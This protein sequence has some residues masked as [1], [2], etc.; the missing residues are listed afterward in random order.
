MAISCA[1]I[2]DG[3]ATAAH[4]LSDGGLLLG[5]AEMAMASGIGADISAAPSNLR[6]CPLV[7]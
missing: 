3:S 1:L 2:L 6:P 7:R 5:I 4:D